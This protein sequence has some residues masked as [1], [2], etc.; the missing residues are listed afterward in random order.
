MTAEIHSDETAVKKTRFQSPVPFIIQLRNLIFGK[1][2]PDTFTQ[3]TFYINLIIWASFVI[4]NILSYYA[5]SS[6]TLIWAKKGIPVEAIIERRGKEL[7]FAK[8]EF[9]DRLLTYH[10][11]SIILWLIA[12]AG[13]VMLYRKKKIFLYLT[14]VPVGLYILMSIFYVSWTYFIQDTTAYDKVALLIFFLS[15]AIQSYLLKNER[16]G[17]GINFFGVDE[18]DQ[19]SE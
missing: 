16:E 18:E 10:S 12:G 11:L 15:I 3:V 7:G 6:R 8:G 9:L 19:P 1:K 13:L 4:W 17:R 14:V 5:I 2:R